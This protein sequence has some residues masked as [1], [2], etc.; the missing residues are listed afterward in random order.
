M[1]RCL[2]V[3]GRVEGLDLIERES[4]DGY[5]FVICADSGQVAAKR[6]G[7]DVDVYL[8]DFDS[9]VAPAGR[10]VHADLDGKTAENDFEEKNSSSEG[11]VKVV[12]LPAEKNVTDS[13]A[14]V[15]YAA[16]RG[17]EVIDVMGGLAGRLDHTLGNLA[18]LEKYC[19]SQV[20]VS[21][22][23]GINRVRLLG[24][25]THEVPRGRYQY[26]GVI[27]QSDEVKGLGL[28]GVKYEVEDFTL[29]AGSTRGVSNEILGESA[30]VTIG[31]GRAL[32]INSRDGVG[33]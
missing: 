20:S 16:S 22:F 27:P 12:V 29:S 23:D 15:D 28:T 6:L 30:Q 31:F 11:S 33:Q 14:A 26:L 18:I 21:F 25:G 8:G 2:V 10:V 4:L 24:P 17:F 7:L 19:E 3:V 13:E 5:N 1:K 9:S 32:V